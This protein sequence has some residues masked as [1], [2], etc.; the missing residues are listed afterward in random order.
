MR[1]ILTGILAVTV[2]FSGISTAKAAALLGSTDKFTVSYAMYAGGFR[3][4]D[5]SLGFDFTPKTYN[6]LMTAKPYGVIGRFLPWAGQHSTKGTISGTSLLPVHHEKIS[7]W[8]EDND[9]AFF[10]YTKGQLTSLKKTEIENGKMTT[11]TDL[12]AP[13]FYKDATDILTGAAQILAT[14]NTGSPCTGKP[15]IF[16]GKRRY[17]LKFTDKGTEALVN[18]KYNMFKGTAH[19]CEVEMIPLLGYKDKPRGY[20][21]VQEEARAKGQLP[22]VWLGQLWKDGP[23]L[24]VKMMVKSEYGA[25]LLHAQKAAH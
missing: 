7:R 25:V 20:Y 11:Y 3:A 18:S 8:G 19:I 2:V 13:E 23:Y 24:P 5:M 4:L 1:R 14:V 9:Q 22:R 16:D 6:I 17:S 10:D 12:P 15:T 21:K